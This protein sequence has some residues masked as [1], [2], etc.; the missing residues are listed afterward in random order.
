M[1]RAVIVIGVYA[2]V[3]TRSLA[4]TRGAALVN[5]DTSAP[6]WS[7]SMAPE[8]N[9]YTIAVTPNVHIV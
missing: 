6:F 2:P 1:Q 3:G 8:K 7:E 9:K 4:S 5:S